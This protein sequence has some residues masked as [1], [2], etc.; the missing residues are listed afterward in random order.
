VKRKKTGKRRGRPINPRARRRQTTRAGRRGELDT[1]TKEL[2]MKKRIAA[3]GSGGTVEVIDIG[4]ILAAHNLIDVDQHMTLRLLETWLM[5][6]A[7][8]R[9]LS[10]ASVGG[11]WGAI[12]SGQGSSRHWTIPITAPDERTAGDMAW[13]RIATISNAFAEAHQLERLNL[14]MAVAGGDCSVA[15]RH[16]LAELHAAIGIVAELLRQ[17]RRRRVYQPAR[18]ETV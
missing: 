6:I 18:A 1:G 2:A 12:L 8:A 11:L 4:G 13:F 5:R 16:E 17:G 15:N 3:N 10:S 9:G 14:L 7:R